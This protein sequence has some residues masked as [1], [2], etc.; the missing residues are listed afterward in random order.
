VGGEAAGFAECGHA[1][2]ALAVEAF[3]ARIFQELREPFARGVAGEVG[4]LSAFDGAEAMAVGAVERDLG[5]KF[6]PF[7]DEC[8]VLR[9]G[10]VLR[11]QLRLGADGGDDF[12]GNLHCK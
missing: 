6:A 10:F 8:D 7:L 5:E 2:V 3:M 12:S 1:I 11:G 9:V 4:R